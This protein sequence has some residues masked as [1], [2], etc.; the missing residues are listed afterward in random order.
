MQ[1]V[2]FT[3]IY[4]LLL[5]CLLWIPQIIKTTSEN[6]VNCPKDT[7]FVIFTTL[8]CTFLP[9]YFMGCDNNI[10]YLRP[11]RGYFW[12]CVFLLLV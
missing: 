10:L 9:L 12:F 5:F 4:S 2:Y 8:H 11:S 3:P 6:N 1:K 7:W